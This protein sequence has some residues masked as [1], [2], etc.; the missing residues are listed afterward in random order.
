[1]RKLLIF[2]IF[3]LFS[4]QAFAMGGTPSESK[5]YAFTLK[6]LAGEQ[7]TLK[8]VSTGK[9]VLLAFFTTW[10]P[11]CQDEMPQLESIYQKNKMK[12]LEVVGIGIRETNEGLTAFAK[13]HNLTFKILMDERGK[14]ATQY[15]VRYI[16]NIFLFDKSGNKVF[17]ANYM[18]AADL[19]KVI[20]KYL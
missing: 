14:V 19:E 12:G 9:V 7:V 10:C 4:A 18:K 16:P 20:N 8:S 3:I 17:N 11:S 2:V 6:D 15:G 13:E 5:N 1:M